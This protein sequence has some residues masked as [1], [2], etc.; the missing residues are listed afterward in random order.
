MTLSTQTGWVP[1]RIL[2]NFVFLN[3]QMFFITHGVNSSTPTVIRSRVGRLNLTPT[4]N[5]A[6]TATVTALGTYTGEI[7]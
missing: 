5:T 4:S 1:S 3:N 6:I 7:D 2:E